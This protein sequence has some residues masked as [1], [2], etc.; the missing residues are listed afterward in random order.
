MTRDE[1]A[2]ALR[3]LLPHLYDPGYTIPEALE[4][5][6]R[7]PDAPETLSTPEIVIAQ[8]QAL[9]PGPRVP[10]TARIHR[11]YEVLHLRYVEHWTQR[12]VADALGITVR[13]LSREQTRA[14]DF[15]VDRIWRQARPSAPIETDR[16]TTEQSEARDGN[17]ETALS[18]SLASLEQAKG[19]NATDLGSALRRAA[20]LVAV[21][22]K[23]HRVT[24]TTAPSA[25]GIMVDVRRSV[26]VQVLVRAL[27]QLVARAEGGEVRVRA[28]LSAAMGTCYL[29]SN[30]YLGEPPTDAELLDSL[31]RSQ[32][33]RV[34]LE[35]TAEGAEVTLCFP[36][37]R[38]R[39]VLVIDDN[40]DL[41][42]YYQQ[43]VANAPYEIHGLT[44][45][46]HAI[47]HAMELAPDI[48]VLDLMLPDTD[49]WDILERIRETDALADVPV[50][51]SSVVGERELALAL[52]ATLCLT[53]P[54][55]R[56]AFVEALDH[57]AHGSP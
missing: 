51:I 19:E 43:C 40:P 31:V 56:A 13:H 36:L 30:R 29:T 4:R 20:K 49:G 57:A 50:I 11:L 21:L 22:A 18:E 39:Q 44:A 37:A 54:V 17:H 16:P 52:G 6:L 2:E 1:F 45:A 55:R 53:K 10:Q 15:L 35:R 41:I 25:P 33:G 3:Q 5:V 12:R 14:V 38:K 24:I 42:H 8:I 28:T 7:Q 48:I 47:E 32:H 34:E 23:S 9:R 27:T 26:L 46:T